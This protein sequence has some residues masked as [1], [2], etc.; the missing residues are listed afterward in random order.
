MRAAAARS[1]ALNYQLH[2]PA[3]PE[4]VVLAGGGAAN[5]HLVSRIC[6]H[7]LTLQPL[8]NIQTSDQLG[9]PVQSVEPAAFAL[10]AYYR[11]RRKPGNIPATTG[12]RRAVLLGQVAEAY[13]DPEPDLHK[14]LNDE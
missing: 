14:S 11:W 8:T 6:A 9:W 7:L 4:Q 12:A 3:R 2:L 5:R 1:L 10:L 13:W